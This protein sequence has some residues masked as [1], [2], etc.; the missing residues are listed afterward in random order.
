MKLEDCKLCKGTGT[1]NERRRYDCY[2]FWFEKIPMVNYTCP[3]CEGT[4][5]ILLSVHPVRTYNYSNK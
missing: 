5:K 1:V 4:K 2:R 3:L